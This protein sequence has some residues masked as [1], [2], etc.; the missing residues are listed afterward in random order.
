LRGR[1]A[2]VVYQGVKSVFKNIHIGV[3]QGSVLSLALFNFFVLDCPDMLGLKVMFADD[4]SAAASAVD[5]RS[6]EA[7]LN[8]DMIVIAAWAK[9]KNLKISPEKFQVNFFKPD[10]RESYVH[11]LIFFEGALLP[12]QRNPRNLGLIL[13]P[14]GMYNANAIH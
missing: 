6:I 1:S 13:D 7:D 2:A 5:L 11:P 10:R 9:R 12:L 8:A 3:P 4:F 14:H